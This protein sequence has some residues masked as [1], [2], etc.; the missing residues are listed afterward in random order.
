VNTLQ[1]V[2]P[3]RTASGRRPDGSAAT[4]ATPRAFEV[5]ESLVVRVEASPEQA[6]ASTRRLDLTRRPARALRALGLADR[7]AFRRASDG[8]GYT[9]VL[10][11]GVELEWEL[12]VAA[13]EGGG[14]LLT[15][16]TRIAAAD[17]ARLLDAWPLVGGVA[18][19]V[20]RD[21]AEA[22]RA[23]AQAD[24]EDRLAA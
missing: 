18:R 10:P 1:I 9:L 2:H 3:R 21:V 16:A 15:V 7:V 19:A 4:G 24:P 11:G 20:A 23:S 12:V 13:A 6:L 14:A 22:A 8:L 5:G 17:G